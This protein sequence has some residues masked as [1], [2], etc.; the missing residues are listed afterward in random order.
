MASDQNLTPPENGE[1]LDD[2]GEETEFPGRGRLRDRLRHPGFRK[3]I[4]VGGG[5]TGLM[6]AAVSYSIWSSGTFVGD[7]RVTQPPRLDTTPGGEIQT[8]SPAYQG[9]LEQANDAGAETAAETGQSF[10]STVEAA[11]E[12]TGTALNTESASL[13]E[14]VAG[15]P[16]L[17][18]VPLPVRV[19]EQQPAVP[20][21]SAGRLPGLEP[22]PEQVPD[23][24]EN[25]S[26]LVLPPSDTTVS[27]PAE[28][29]V[30]PPAAESPDVQPTR[31]TDPL[32]A[33][34]QAILGGSAVP[35]PE[36][37]VFATAMTGTPSVP[38]EALPPAAVGPDPSSHLLARA[39]DI[40][41]ATTLNT[42]DS[43]NAPATLVA[44]V[45]SGPL[46][47]AR[48]VGTV[49]APANNR[50]G[51]LASF[52]GVS[53]PGQ[54]LR[55]VEAFGITLS[56]A[57]QQLHSSVEQ[58]YLSRYGPAF[59]LGV[60]GAGARHLATSRRRCRSEV[61]YDPDT[62]LATGTR[63]VDCDYGGMSPDEEALAAGVAAGTGAIAADIASH[64]PRGPR[65]WLI[66]GSALGVLLQSDIPQNPSETGVTPAR[67]ATVSPA[68]LSGGPATANNV[69]SSI[70]DNG[71]PVPTPAALALPALDAASGFLEQQ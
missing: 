13:P 35:V 57:R 7:S 69:V 27:V 55:P 19:P 62:R 21:R 63:E 38:A 32:M 23:T 5:V 36:A 30:L 53:L 25:L 64:T 70:L 17:E 9:A 65:T 61:I 26:P 14:P 49:N 44:E 8:T 51:L 41:F 33:Q 48:F 52:T 50:A 1:P 31:I 16:L 45:T 67:A 18:V 22:V 59:L 42:V 34:M 39:G 4:L 54:T 10:V 15:L 20:A 28:V 37:G 24:T 56:G 40:L 71:L 12:R 11:A 68:E 46:A 2:F 6:L 58:R 3:M 43:D 66:R 47:G 60:V 29:P